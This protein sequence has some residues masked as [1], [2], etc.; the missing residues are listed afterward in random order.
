MQKAALPVS[1]AFACLL[2]AGCGRSSSAQIDYTMG[3]KVTVGPLTYSVNDATWKGQLGEGYQVRT[4]NQRFLLL[5]VSVTNGGGGDVSIPLL[6][7]E[8]SGGHRYQEVPNGDGVDQYIGILRNIS[9]AQTLQGRLVFDVPLT[10]YRL[11]VVDGGD[12]AF[13]KFAWVQIPLNL[14]ADTPLLTPLPG[15]AINAIK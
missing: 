14:N 1:I 4:P 3:E 8:D 7:L 10:S 5:S 9:P 6:Q 11:R 15:G 2:L 13:E 12:P